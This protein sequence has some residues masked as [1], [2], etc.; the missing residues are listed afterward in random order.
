VT[1]PDAPAAAGALTVVTANLEHG[2]APNGDDSSL[3]TTIAAIAPLHPD[4]VLLQEVGVPDPLQTW[5]LMHRL[6]AAMG[7]MRPIL[8]PPA[9]AESLCGSHTAILAAAH[10]TVTDQWPPPAPAGPAE[11]WCS[12]ELADPRLPGPLLV[13]SAHLPIGSRAALLRAAQLIASF[14]AEKTGDGILVMAGGNMN[15]Y[16]RAGAPVVV[17]DLPLRLE[18]ARTVPG[19]AGRLIPDLSADDTLTA[20]LPDAG[21]VLAARGAG[22]HCLAPT[23]RW[24]AR[25][26]RIHADSALTTA[27]VAYRAIAIGSGHQAVAVTFDLAR[28]PSAGVPDPRPGVSPTR[29]RHSP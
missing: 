11:P 2:I 27:A 3:R 10:V 28:L 23:G 16:P 15:C 5:R 14:A 7:D 12:A 21:A 13:I 1:T 26:D 25:E 4:I 17:D 18:I 22:P 29:I 20:V 6:A 8:G 24:G 19:P 9:A